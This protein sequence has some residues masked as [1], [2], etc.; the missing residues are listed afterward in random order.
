MQ[1]RHW[2][3]RPRNVRRLW[4][5]F[6]AVL[7]LTL[8]AEPLVTQHPYFGIDGIFGFHAWFGFAACAVLILG[9][10]LLGVA[11]KRKDAYYDD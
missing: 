4:S 6:I 9:S 1:D 11:L 3:T 7:A 2:L 10:K 8:A 5:A